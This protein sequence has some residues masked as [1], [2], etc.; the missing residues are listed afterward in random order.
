MPT[1]VLLQ[2]DRHDVYLTHVVFHMCKYR[3]RSRSINGGFDKAN[4]SI[5]RLAEP[6]HEECHAS[7]DSRQNNRQWVAGENRNEQYHWYSAANYH[8]GN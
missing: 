6:G 2:F 5:R 4:T 8:P 7:H 3:Y 1:F